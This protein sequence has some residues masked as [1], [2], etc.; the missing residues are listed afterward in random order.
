MKY[1]VHSHDGSLLNS[2]GHIAYPGPVN[3]CKA[4]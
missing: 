3:V 1:L 4:D 2:T